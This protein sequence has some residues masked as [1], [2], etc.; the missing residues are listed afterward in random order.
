MDHLAQETRETQELRLIGGVARRL[1][2]E[3]LT[4][5][6]DSDVRSARLRFDSL[7]EETLAACV[8]AVAADRQLFNPDAPENEAQNFIDLRIPRELV[9]AEDI[10]DPRVL[11][12]GNAA[13]ARNLVTD[14]RILLF[15][16]GP[17]SLVEDTL[18]EVISIS[19]KDLLEQP[20]LWIPGVVSLLP[21]LAGN[22]AIHDQLLA[23]FTG[24]TRTMHRS[25]VLCARHL[26]ESA[27]FVA[28]GAPVDEAASEALPALR[29]PK[30]RSAMPRPKS[31]AD[32][33]A[34]AKSFELV[35]GMP[36]GL[37]AT[38]ARPASMPLET[39]RRNLENLAD[40][41]LRAEALELYEAIASDADGSGERRWSELLGL[42]WEADALEDF[43]CAREA[44]PER[45]TLGRETLDFFES[46]HNEK[47]GNMIPGL[48]RP[49]GEFLEDFAQNDRA[50]HTE[51]FRDEA[52]LFLSAA[53]S[54]LAEDSK[55]FAKWEKIVF[56]RVIEGTDF[57]DCILQA[58]FIL[59]R[60][61]LADRARLKDPVLLLTCQTPT[62]RFFEET[63][64]GLIGAFSA[65]CRGL[66][67]ECPGFIAFRF[68]SL[69][70][71]RTGGLNPLFHFN[72]A[73]ARLPKYAKKR[74]SQSVSKEALQITFLAALTER[75]KE[76]AQA[77]R[78]TG[79]RIVWK[80]PKNGMGLNLARDLAGLLEKGKDGDHAFRILAGR[81]YRQANAK[82]V[83]S[84]ISLSEPGSFGIGH[85]SFVS[86]MRRMKAGWDLEKAFDDLLAASETSTVSA[87][88]A[89]WDDFRTK[90]RAALAAALEVGL[91]AAEIADM[92][93][94]FGE[95]LR[96][97][98]K[99]SER[100]QRFRQHALSTLL[101]V[102]VF[103]FASGKTVHAV[104]TPW[105]PLRLFELH[106][107]FTAKTAL[108][109]EL[110][111]NPEDAP[112]DPE[113]FVRTLALRRESHAP[114][115]V[116]CPEES[117]Q[118]NDALVCRM[119]LAPIE[120]DCGYTLLS[121]VCGP[122]CRAA[123]ADP[124]A[125]AE[126][127]EVVE[128]NYLSLMPQATN[129]LR[130]L[131]PD[132]DGRDFPLA[133]MR[134]LAE[135]LPED[136]RIR[137]CAGGLGLPERPYCRE[138]ASALFSGLL[139]AT[140]RSDAMREESL[141]STS[142][143]SRL[144]FSVTPADAGLTALMATPDDGV[145]PFDLAFLDRFFT[146]R[147]SIDWV[148]LPRR[149]APANPYNLFESLQPVSRRLVEVGREFVSSTLLAAGAIDGP[150]HA[151][152][153]AV[154]MLTEDKPAED[155]ARFLYP[156]LRLDCS[157]DEI[158]REIRRIHG[159][160]QWV[161]TS[162][163]LIDRRQLLQSSI[164][165]VRYKRNA[166]TGRTSI[167]SSQMPTELIA[168]RI[169]RLVRSV[170]PTLQEET[171]KAAAEEV[172]ACA[173]SISGFLAL[174]SARSDASACEITGL[175]LSNRIACAET[176]RLIE[177][178]GEG[179]IARTTL[180]VDDY[181]SVFKNRSKLADLLVLT[182]CEREGR[183]KLHIAVTEAKFWRSASISDAK[184]TSSAQAAATAEILVKALGGSASSAPERPVWFSR[185]ADMLLTLDSKG[186]NK[187]ADSEALIGFAYR[188]R[189]GEFDITVNAASHVF[190][191]D[192][193][194]P[195]E[196]ASLDMDVEGCPV[197]QLVLRREAVA[198]LLGKTGTLDWA[199]L[200]EAMGD[201]PW[202][203]KFNEIELGAPW[204][205]AEGLSR[206]TLDA[207]QE[208]ETPPKS[209]N[210][211]EEENRDDL[212]NAEEDDGDDHPAVETA[213]MPGKSRAADEPADPADPAEP[214][215]A[216]GVEEPAPNV[217]DPA[218]GGS[219][220]PATGESRKFGEPAAPANGVILVADEPERVFAPSF[221]RLV[222]E[223]GG[224][225]T[226]SK[227]R[228]DWA[229]AASK[230]LQ[231]ALAGKGVPARILRCKV[232][233]NGC[234]VCFEGSEKLTTQ[235][236][237]KMREYLLSAKSINIIFSKPAPGEFRI[238]FN[239]G[240][241]R[242]EPVS[243]WSA[244][245]CQSVRRESGLNHSFV[246]G[247]KESDGEL[248]HLD[249]IDQSP[250]TLIG[251]DTGSGK[252]AL[253]QCLLLDMAA[254]NPS[255]LLKIRLI[256]PKKGVDFAP[257]RALPHLD[258]DPVTDISEI[259]AAIEGLIEEMERRYKLFEANG[260]NKLATYNERAAPEERL[261]A[262]FLVHDELAFCM[263]DP[264]YKKTVPPLLIKLA[265]K[266]RAAGIFLI[267]IAQRPDKDV[268]PPQ[269]RDNL[270]NRLILKMPAAASVFALGQ[271]GAERLLGKGHMAASLSNELEYAQVP[272]L[273]DRNEVLL[274]VAQAI[275]ETDK[276]WR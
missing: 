261:P 97:A 272:F 130:I 50:K 129:C 63:N 140:S 120:H 162:N 31:F 264:E 1:V 36:E 53:E 21:Q 44:A 166:S 241:G 81:N 144:A 26:I 111:G 102:G 225:F 149:K 211:E 5:C 136:E 2:S 96:V 42:D 216:A 160:A 68:K 127:T 9:R 95:L 121:H 238:L 173:H 122:N 201:A 190:V 32:P 131:L 249:P 250:H 170:A 171:I 252:T 206:N 124:K 85:A 180:L 23:M 118:E 219:G 105:N 11:F 274:E 169:R 18:K 69:S 257:I 84:E 98:A 57:I 268:V 237:E 74:A 52:R 75:G 34:W 184:K 193:E 134:D 139:D 263:Q 113:G 172:L 106:R 119:I 17:T 94:A 242:R 167:V 181:A 228:E 28:A 213:E 157:E 155:G 58:A 276:E 66:E 40:K 70:F 194:G 25:L 202:C 45:R 266:S 226:Y 205:W 82:G 8:N 114:A 174:R 46:Q 234:L 248:L 221:E 235:A 204:R 4:E 255:S 141:V 64:A 109:G 161:V 37:F 164:R 49:V 236:I 197:T 223:K 182:L 19:E 59:A 153:N 61:S 218:S 24:F 29:L 262:I 123:G 177:E 212:R 80:L 203:P 79:I 246:I 267:L 196:C 60:Q 115:I 260:T 43:L 156:A 244:W 198:R 125:V 86:A 232:T 99:S 15:A 71:S 38:D 189:R 224:D 132:A 215:G 240:S 137:I 91:G 135:K 62:R 151:W 56:P 128:K 35:R 165:I 83:L 265:T 100:S 239:D 207:P 191:R 92:H 208:N 89:A 176:D 270:G 20:A 12:D 163:E 143:R 222:W 146:T 227:E 258:G 271:K 217:S 133:V 27:R 220:A 175:A 7:G 47:L 256:D 104:A 87:V 126:L 192:E 186:L 30:W 243:M 245:R 214:A 185:L 150:G 67:T 110:I 108:I 247:L 233:P 183:L 117:N 10:R 90:Y 78:N 231:M 168:E 14:K 209:F 179:F 55:L 65:L 39:L 210:P 253:V 187:S 93:D 112:A 200:D 178:A 148:A 275:A 41:G 16:N 6:R 138:E 199:D 251:G 13:A 142:L 48:R 3:R 152:L 159:L 77:K 273:S 72:E 154:S 22:A 88:R 116:V 103:S 254:T 230:T 107:D 33:R 54:V 76:D 195:A 101:S 229:S 259:P 158:L 73:R 145:R 188:I 51:E 269:V 147:A